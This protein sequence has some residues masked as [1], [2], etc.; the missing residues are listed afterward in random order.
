MSEAASRISLDLD[1][2]RK[3]I[4]E[5]ANCVDSIVVS[6]LF[7]VFNHLHEVEV[8]RLIR[9][10]YDIPVVMGHELTGELGI[11]ER[12]VTAVLNA[13]LIPVLRR[14]PEKGPGDHGPAGDQGAR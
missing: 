4:D 1:G 12:T 6:G 7:S 10:R 3:A 14:L 8:K 2:A 9:E 13:G 11:Y 5:M